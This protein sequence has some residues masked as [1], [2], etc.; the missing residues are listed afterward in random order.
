MSRRV[1]TAVIVGGISTPTRS[2]TTD[3]SVSSPVATGSLVMQAPRPTQVQTGAS[4]VIYAGYDGATQPI[5]NGRIAKDNA[6]F[7][8]DG[9]EL[10]VTLEGWSALLY[11][12]YLE[13][14]GFYGPMRLDTW[15][16]SLC[17]TMGVPNYRADVATAP[18][19]VDI[20]LGDNPDYRAR[21]I[22]INGD[23]S[24]GSDID[25]ILELF[26][27]RGFDTPLGARMQRVSGLPTEPAA[28]LERYT[29]GV[30]VLGIE[31]VRSRDG[32]ANIVDVRG[33]EYQAPDTSEK[34]LRSFTG[35]YTPD[36]RYGPTGMNTL[37]VKDD[38]LG[39]VALAN[40]SRNAYEIDRGGESL[41]FSWEG[42]GDPFRIPGEQ[43]ALLSPTVNGST[44]TDATARLIANLPLAAWLMSVRHTIT[45]RGWT[46]AMTGW[47]GTGQA[48]PAGNDCITISLLGSSGRHVGN[49]YLAHYRRPNPDGL[50]VRIAFSV[51]DVYSTLTI[52]GWHHGTN[53][54]VRN[55]DSTA[56]RFEIWQGGSS[57][58][59]GEMPRSDE[60]LEQRRNYSL[61]STWDT[62][63]VPLTGSLTAGGA[64]LRIISGKDSAVGDQDDYEVRNLTL[65]ACGVGV[66]TPI[67]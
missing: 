1:T 50:D 2:I 38:I 47:A 41:R 56:S 3:H 39:S 18:S 66:P 64:E 54:F 59:S 49:E 23:R 17:N 29:Q 34:A 33:A 24:P 27:Y 11:N 31:R 21:W 37:H 19:G 57:K 60:Y 5:F 67:I 26:G 40:A 32:M 30:N 48:L 35:T 43:V 52:R 9:G 62:L 7:D 12:K 28:N 10:R 45:D 15:W 55:T 51:P 22:P 20:V 6:G 25:R 4:V 36:D 44:S 42:V 14:R 16:R 58:A 65:T 53:S 13:G 46:T 63:V 61:D 8:T